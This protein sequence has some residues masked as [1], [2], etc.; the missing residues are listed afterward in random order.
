MPR[1][2]GIVGALVICAGLDLLG[3]SRHEIRFWI[4]AYMKF[5]RVM[6]RH[7]EPLKVFPAKEAAEKLHG[8]VRFLLGMGFA[9]FRGPM[10]MFYTTL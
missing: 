1:L 4:A 2:L 6:L 8:A 10:L 3:Q 7:E 9:F 5:F